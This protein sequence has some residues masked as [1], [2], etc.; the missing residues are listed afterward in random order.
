MVG[1]GWGG[2]GR[3]G[4]SERGDRRSGMSDFA[5]LRID[6]R[7]FGITGDGWRWMRIFP[8]PSSMGLRYRSWS[9]RI[10]QRG[11]GGFLG[12]GRLGGGFG[13]AHGGGGLGGRC[14]ATQVPSE[15]RETIQK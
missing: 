4:G 15:A 1:D 13:G 5:R 14:G 11:T 6:W 8:V 12:S 2:L 7:E 9:W 10:G 3:C